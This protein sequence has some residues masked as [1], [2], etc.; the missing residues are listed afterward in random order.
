MQRSTFVF[1]QP[2][3]GAGMAG[4][5]QREVRYGQNVTDPDPTPESLGAAINPPG[6]A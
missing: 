2:L 6:R 4:Y 5:R 1:V 3:P